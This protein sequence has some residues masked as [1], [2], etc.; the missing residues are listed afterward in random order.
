M[1][2][3]K[4]FINMFLILGKKSHQEDYHEE[5]N[6]QSLSTQGKKKKKIDS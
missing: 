6:N 2:I 3:D 4:K 1:Q 5:S